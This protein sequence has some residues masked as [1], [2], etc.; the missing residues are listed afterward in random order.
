MESESQDGMPVEGLHCPTCGGEVRNQL[1]AKLGRC[2]DCGK[3]MR[4]VV[5]SHYSDIEGLIR[6]RGRVIL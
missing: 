3:A 2:S 6:S 1:D 4:I 5:Q